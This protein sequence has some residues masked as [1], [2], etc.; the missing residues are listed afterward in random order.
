[1]WGRKSYIRLTGSGISTFIHDSRPT[2]HPLEEGIVLN[3]RWW[4][5]IWDY[6]PWE[7]VLG[8]YF[9]T[10]WGRVWIYNSC[11]WFVFSYVLISVVPSWE[12]SR[13]TIN[14]KS[15]I[16][17]F[18]CMM[19]ILSQRTY[20]CKVLWMIITCS[21]YP[22]WNKHNWINPINRKNFQDVWGLIDI[23]IWV[24]LNQIHCSFLFL[25]LGDLS[26]ASLPTFCSG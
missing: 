13:N 19:W 7:S 24:C 22:Y 18:N 6:L 16:G 5:P 10:Y 4:V 3:G 26:H 11:L 14:G 25:G 2:S 21:Y 17:L 20:E 15:N 8:G 1:M 9:N 12:F 23:L